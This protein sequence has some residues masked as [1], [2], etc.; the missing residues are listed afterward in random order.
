[1]D[2]STVQLEGIGNHPQLC[3]T[4]RNRIF[5]RDSVTGDYVLA[6]GPFKFQL[7]DGYFP[8]RLDLKVTYPPRPCA[9]T[10]SIPRSRTASS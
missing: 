8:M 5:S 2:G 10:V 3:L 1:M 7:F 9:W 6:V 4:S